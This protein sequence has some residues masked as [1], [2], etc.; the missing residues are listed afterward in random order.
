M[1]IAAFF[2]RER[3]VARL[4]DLGGNPY[5]KDRQ[6]KTVYELLSN[7]KIKRLMT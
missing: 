3:V 6:G 1:Y 2:K 5:I 7:K 4:V